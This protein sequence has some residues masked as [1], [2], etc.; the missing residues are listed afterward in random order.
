MKNLIKKIMKSKYKFLFVGILIILFV[1]FI[2]AV[3][4]TLLSDIV[5]H[6]NM[7]YEN[8][9]VHN[10]YVDNNTGRYVIANDHGINFEMLNDTPGKK[11]YNQIGVGQR[12]NM[13]VHETSDHSFVRLI[14]VNNVTS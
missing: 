1:F 10:K 13:V 11:L 5:E 3:T 7:Y 6:D 4:I 12:Y 14:R 9:L 8:V 2:G